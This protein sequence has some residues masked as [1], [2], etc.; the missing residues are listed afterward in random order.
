MR[1]ERKEVSKMKRGEMPPRDLALLGV[2]V[3][4]MLGGA[5]TLVAEWIV[6]GIAIPAITVGIALVVIGQVDLYHR[7]RRAID[8]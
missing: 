2:A 1:D 4:L 3:V 7:Q 6:P 8:G 5:V